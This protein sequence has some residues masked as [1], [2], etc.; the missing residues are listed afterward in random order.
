MSSRYYVKDIGRLRT[1]GQYLSRLASRIDESLAL[2]DQLLQA[3]LEWIEDRKH[4]WAREVQRRQRALDDCQAQSDEKK[5]YGCSGES[6]ALAAAQEALG[7]AQKWAVR[8]EQAVAEYQGHAKATKRLA[9]S[10][11]AKASSD[12]GG[13]VGKYEKYASSSTLRGSNYGNDS[14]KGGLTEAV[15]SLMP[16]QGPVQKIL[17]GALSGTADAAGSKTLKESG[18]QLLSGIIQSFILPGPVR[19]ANAGVQ[20]GGHMAA[21]VRLLNSVGPG[22]DLSHLHEHILQNERWHQR[23]D[24]LNL[25]SRVDG[26]VRSSWDALQQ[27]DFGVALNGIQHEFRTFFGE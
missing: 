6:Q 12:L 15:G 25:D 23:I 13:I 10:D 26:I 19:W 18:V 8:I 24:G 20:V 7:K 2:S 17:G 22:K 16:N 3:E 5:G 4:F 21:D 9:S 11:I 1:F 14:I 27:K